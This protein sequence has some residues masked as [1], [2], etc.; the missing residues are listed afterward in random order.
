[1]A[2]FTPTQGRYR[3]FIHAYIGPHGSPP[4]ESEIAAAGRPR[5]Q[6]PAATSYYPTTSTV[7]AAPS[8]RSR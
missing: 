3:A 2:D 5:S 8:T 1:M 7:P 6:G 4:A